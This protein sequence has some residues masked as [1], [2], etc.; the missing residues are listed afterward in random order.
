MAMLAANVFRGSFTQS[1]EI[2]DVENVCELL[3]L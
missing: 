1:I 3:G 2:V